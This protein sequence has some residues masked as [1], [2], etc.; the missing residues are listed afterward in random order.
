MCAWFF[1]DIGR[2]A[3]DTYT[4]RLWVVHTPA[5]MSSKRSAPPSSS[6][7]KRTKVGK[8]VATKVIIDTD[9]GIDDAMAIMTALAPLTEEQLA[10]TNQ[11]PLEVTAGDVAAEAVGAVQLGTDSCFRCLD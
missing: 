11:T 5:A 9:P 7:S 4:L 1:F 8:H 2:I 10:E 6:S 3:R